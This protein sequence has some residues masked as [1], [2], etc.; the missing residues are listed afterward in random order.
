MRKNILL[1]LTVC[2]GTISVLAQRNQG[3]RFTAMGNATAA[4]KDLWSLN[5]NPAGITNQTKPVAGINYARFFYGDEL[6]EQNLA[7]VIPLKGNYAGVNIGRYGITE[8]NEISVGVALAKKFGES[9]SIA[10][11]GNIHQ[12]KISNY[13]NANAFS[14]DVGAIYALNQKIN[15]GVYVNNPSLQKYKTSNVVAPIATA[16]HLGATYEPSNK[17]IIAATVTKTI[18]EKVDVALGVD[19]K[20]L[21][22]LSLRGGL[23]AK[24]FKQYLGI[25]LN[26]EKFLLDIAVESHP[27]IGYTPQIGLSYAF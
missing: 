8:F 13:G 27:K 2:C 25:G 15:L 17:V 6:S 16:F 14:V 7:C 19:Y 9:F 12:L 3:A 23:S 20:F 4:V 18:D 21:N 1:F 26:Y 10:L 5:A 11:K 22:I 24:S